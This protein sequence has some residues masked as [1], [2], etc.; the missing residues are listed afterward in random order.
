MA[1]YVIY[2]GEVLDQERYE[3][4][5]PKAAASI[6]AAGG[7]YLIRGGEVE[8]LAPAGRTVVLEFSTMQ[9]ARAWY[10]TEEYNEIRKIR[11][12]AARVRMYIVDG[13]AWPTTAPNC[14]PVIEDAL[15]P[16]EKVQP[17]APASRR[18]AIASSVLPSAFCASPRL[19]HARACRGDGL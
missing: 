17:R 4:Y 5:K 2:E 10:R 16:I 7:R 11:E 18:A 3:D 6:V 19:Y 15:A 13:F 12:G 1:A 9:A 8:V 14:R